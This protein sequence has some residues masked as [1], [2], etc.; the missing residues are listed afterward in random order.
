MS[1]KTI[2]IEENFPPH[3][4]SIVIGDSKSFLPTKQKPPEPK[5]VKPPKTSDKK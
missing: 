3:I 5:N 1:E 2:N 4:K